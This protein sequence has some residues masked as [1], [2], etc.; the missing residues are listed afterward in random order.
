MARRGLQVM[1]ALLAGVALSAGT[2]TVLTG[3]ST[4]LA[5][6]SVSPS[7][8]SELRFY[9]AWY[10]GLGLV[11]LWSALHVESATTVIRAVCA[12]L[13]VGALG[14]VIS[15][16]DAGRP[17]DLYLVLLAVEVTLP[18]VLVPWQGRVARTA[19]RSRGAP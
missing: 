18:A 9:A 7:V 12:V 19:V 6:G 8:D 2:V 14:R 4:I 16:S 5:S 11:L 17:H 13:L 15:W 3:A 1:L 10:A